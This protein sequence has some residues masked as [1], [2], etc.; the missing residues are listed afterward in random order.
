MTLIARRGRAGCIAIEPL[1]NDPRPPSAVLDLLDPPQDQLGIRLADG[2][3]S[4]I[5]NYRPVIRRDE[6]RC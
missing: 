5:W 6:A 2:Q 4:H 1:A 3:G